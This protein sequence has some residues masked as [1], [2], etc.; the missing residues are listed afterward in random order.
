[1]GRLYPTSKGGAMAK[2][3]SSVKTESI[4]VW[5][6]KD[7]RKAIEAAAARDN[8][9]MSAWIELTLKRALEADREH[10]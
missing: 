7:L 8:R 6:D 2:R 5:V 9:T 10:K 3:R 4:K 1:M